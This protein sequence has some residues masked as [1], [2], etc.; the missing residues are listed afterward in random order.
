MTE[1]SYL[2]TTRTAYDT[3]AVDYAALLRDEL[4]RRPLD[5]AMLATFAELVQAD[6]GGQVADIGCGPGRVTAHLQAL[7]VTAFGIDLSP[8]MIAVARQTYPGLRFDEGSMHALDLA[9][10]T[11]DGVVAWYSVIHTPLEHLP[12][13]FAEFHRVLVPGGH[14]LLAFQVGD[15]WRRI[16]QAYGHELALDAYSLSPDHVVEQ[17]GQAGF[18]EIARL[19]RRP[20]GMEKLDQAYVLL[21]KPGQP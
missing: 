17:L 12:S 18:V 3:V 16:S 11:L 21:R 9:D 2:T 8:Q 19:L 10:G 5:R 6:G 7:G 4:D 15:G 14:L 1:A 13:V 20:S